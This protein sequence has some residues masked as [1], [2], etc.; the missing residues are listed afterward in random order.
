MCHKFYGVPMLLHALTG[1]V[2]RLAWPSVT[3]LV[4]AS[5]WADSAVS[6]L[7]QPSVS[8]IE[9]RPAQQPLFTADSVAWS[10]PGAARMQ[11]DVQGKIKSFPYQTQAQLDWLPHGQRYEASQSV[12]VPIV[13]IRRQ[14]STGSIAS[15]GLLPEVFMDTGRK[16]YSTTFDTTARQI[17]F[18][19]GSDPAP[20]IAGTQDRISV[21]FQVAGMLA[22]APQRYPVGTQITLQTASSSRVTP[23]IFT[24]RG[25]ET[26]QLPAGR[27]EAIHLEHQSESSQHDG[28]QSSLWLAPSL[29][30]LPV[31]IL[32]REDAGRDVLDLKLKSHSKP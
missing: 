10:A 20:W 23:W 8:P 26:L 30:Y 21:F 17:R 16:E 5:L 25:S 29:Q 14:S 32:L 3:W 19:R 13:G 31:R 9:V 7:V 2:P 11:F 6:G 15:Q 12:Q 1:L 18:S 28:L 24:V 22:A 27:L 4:A